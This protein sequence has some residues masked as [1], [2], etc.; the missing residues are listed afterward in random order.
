MRLINTRR[1]F[2][3]S[4]GLGASCAATFSSGILPLVANAAATGSDY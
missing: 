2:L 1:T 4:M 3:K